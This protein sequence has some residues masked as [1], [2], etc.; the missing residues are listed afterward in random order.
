MAVVR[1][2]ITSKIIFF[3]GTVLN[4]NSGAETNGHM[5]DTESR[6]Y[7]SGR[8]FDRMSSSGVS[9]LQVRKSWRYD[10]SCVITSSFVIIKFK[11]YYFV[12]HRSTSVPLAI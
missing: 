7:T 12:N 2:N 4:G 8:E 1:V 3:L 9:E 10:S 11:H 6:G 5:T